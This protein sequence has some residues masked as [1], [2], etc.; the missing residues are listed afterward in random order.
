M[1]KGKVYFHNYLERPT[2]ERM[3][4]SAQSYLGL[5][6]QVGGGFYNCGG[7]IHCLKVAADGSCRA[8]W[9]FCEHCHKRQHLIFT[10][11]PCCALF[12]PWMYT[13]KRGVWKEAR[14]LKWGDQI[15]SVS[16]IIQLCPQSSHSLLLS[17]HC[18]PPPTVIGLNNGFR[19]IPQGFLHDMEAVKK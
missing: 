18:P 8:Q 12:T 17:T 7:V 5:S 3:Q 15:Q 19:I 13:I 9:P 10:T 4:L 11:G 1:V 14:R 6:C 16:F 2:A